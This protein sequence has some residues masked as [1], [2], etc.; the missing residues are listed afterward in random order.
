MVRKS[1]I[2][3]NFWY[4]WLNTWRCG[5]KTATFDLKCT[6]P[7]TSEEKFGI[8][9][10]TVE[11]LNGRAEEINLAT[12]RKLGDSI[13]QCI[14]HLP[15]PRLPQDTR[16]KWTGLQIVQMHEETPSSL[17]S[18]RSC[19]GKVTN[20]SRARNYARMEDVQHDDIVSRRN[21]D[22]ST[23]NIALARGSLTVPDGSRVFIIFEPPGSYLDPLTPT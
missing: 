13:T 21:G 19:H 9:N 8:C 10:L 12:K 1:N 20:R 16:I 22:K 15:R 5:I 11:L 18:S 4:F 7:Q 6:R 14:C 3:F 2:C 23:W 17:V